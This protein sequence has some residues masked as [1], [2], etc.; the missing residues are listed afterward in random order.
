MHVATVLTIAFGSLAFAA[1]LTSRAFCDSACG[2]GVAR[3]FPVCDQ[4]LWPTGGEEQLGAV[5]TCVAELCA[6]SSVEVGPYFLA[7]GVSD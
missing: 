2:P 5:A 4:S 7:L 3:D 1:P 6:N